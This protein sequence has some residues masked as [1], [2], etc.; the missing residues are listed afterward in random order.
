MRTVKFRAWDKKKKQMMGIDYPD[1]WEEAIAESR[2]RFDK[3]ILFGITDMSKDKSLV[4]TQWTGLKDSKGVEIYEGDVVKESSD[5]E[6]VVLF[7]EFQTFWKGTVGD[8][9]IGWHL[10][11]WRS[12]PEK[13]YQEGYALSIQDEDEG[14][15]E[16]IGNI[17]ENANL[18]TK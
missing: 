10:R 7:G 2:E 4:L 9:S 8:A 17:Y 12:S 1:K 6:M 13:R 11:L 14:C 15:L 3:T 16:V 5:Y 18:L